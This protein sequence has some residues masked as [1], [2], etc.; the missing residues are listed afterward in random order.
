MLQRKKCK[1]KATTPEGL[2]ALHIAAENGHLAATKW[3]I[4]FAGLDV[5]CVSRAGLTAADLAARAGSADV[6][7]YLQDV[8]AGGT[9]EAEWSRHMAC[10]NTHT[11]IHLHTH[12]CSNI[13]VCI[14]SSV[15]LHFLIPLS[16]Y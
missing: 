9:V 2:T 5:A 16:L 7:A 1:L 6:V 11:D 8:S 15:S 10:V 3:L 14:C 13:Y 4:G 12:T